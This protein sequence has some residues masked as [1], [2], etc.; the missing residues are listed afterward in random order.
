MLVDYLWISLLVEWAKA[1]QALWETGHKWANERVREG[2]GRGALWKPRS[3]RFRRSGRSGPRNGSGRTPACLRYRCSEA[4]STPAELV[5]E[6]SLQ[7]VEVALDVDQRRL[8]LLHVHCAGKLQVQLVQREQVGQ[9]RGVA[10]DHHV[11]PVGADDGAAADV[12]RGIRNDRQ[13]ERGGRGGI[14]VLAHL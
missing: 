5:V 3:P 1:G 7:R 10:H 6:D 8:Q 13:G 2:P 4:W 12:V 14:D 9:R 11:A